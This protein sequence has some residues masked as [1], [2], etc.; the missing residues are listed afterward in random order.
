[1]PIEFRQTMLDMALIDAER[2][3]RLIQ[4]IL[5]LYKLES[6]K[7]YRR[8]EPMQLQEALEFA[9]CGLRGIWGR[10]HLPTIAIELSPQL[11]C[12]RVDGEG[13][14]EVLTKLLDN[15]CKFTGK[16]GQVSIQAQV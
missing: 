8:P 4:D 12:V 1:M 10:D 13:L 2:L 5:T 3:R 9:L 16:D 14:V 15:A 6:G 11:P 7:T